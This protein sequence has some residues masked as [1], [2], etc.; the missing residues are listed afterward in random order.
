MRL[1]K[2]AEGPAVALPAPR[3][4][5]RPSGP[6]GTEQAAAVERLRARFSGP[7][8]VTVLLA[9]RGRGKSAAI[10]LALPSEARLSG[11]H[12][13]AIAE[14]LRFSGFSGHVYEPP[15][16]L[17]Q[18]IGR[19]QVVVVD[20]AAGI[21]LAWLRAIVLAHRNSHLVLATTTGGYEGTGQGFRLR[22]LPWLA[23]VARSL[24]VIHLETPIR[25]GAG[26]PLEAWAR[27]A[28]LLDL[29][30]PAE[31]GPGL[32]PGWGDREKLVLEE[33]RLRAV[34]ALLGQAHYR[35][36]P[37]DLA[38]VLDAPNLHLAW[39]AGPGGVGAV[40]VVSEEGGWTPELAR[41]VE[42]GSLRIRGHALPDTLSVHS[43]IEGIGRLRA[44]RSV[45]LVVHPDRRGEGLAGRL[46]R[47]VQQKPGFDLDGT[48]FAADAAVVRMRRTQGL[49][50]VRVGDATGERSGEP[51]VVM[52]RARTPR[53]EDMVRRAEQ[54]FVRSW[55]GQRA[56]WAGGVGFPL[57]GGLE[58]ALSQDLPAASPWEEGEVERAV[59]SWADG[60][61]TLESVAAE[62]EAWLQM[63][64][65]SRLQ[66]RC[67]A[68]LDR[69]LGGTPWPQVAEAG[70]WNS[71]RAAMREIRRSVA[72]ILQDSPG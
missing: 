58:R 11:P 65:S 16:S 21:P 52:V 39:L 35:S 10:G 71:V 66:P 61:R 32:E 5:I 1:L 8:G 44:L 38:A 59:R 42:R 25:W 27:E 26:D 15:A 7:P 29:P 37:S 30:L 31:P 64:P 36:T 63:P 67:R 60:P 17:V 55:P 24:E 43:G 47:F 72:A 12:P 28:L 33:S 23:D 49:R 48:L 2:H 19:H 14:I 41:A 34:W 20:E 56:R 69:R 46:S 50:V 53:A 70:G 4:A 6:V 62:L 40:N 3:P 13:Q 18:N 51:S 45:R 68:A 22:V 9:D 57:D 54:T